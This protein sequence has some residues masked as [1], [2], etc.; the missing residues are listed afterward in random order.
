V[1]SQQKGR[2]GCHSAW[3]YKGYGLRRRISRL[4]KEG[5]PRRKTMKLCSRILTA[6]LACLFL[7]AS[8]FVSCQRGVE[9][10][11]EG[12]RLKAITTLF[13][14]YDFAKNIGGDKVRVTLLL[15]PGV[16]PHSFEPKP[17][18]M[19]KVMAAD[20]FIYTGGSMEPWAEGI[21]K[22]AENKN[23]L[24]VDASRGIDLTQQ[25]AGVEEDDHGHDHG[26]TDPHI[27][28]DMSKAEKMVDNILEGLIKKD[29]TNREYYTRNADSYKTRLREL[30]A[31]YRS[32]LST[33]KKRTFIHGGHFAFGYLAKR[34]NLHYISAYHG[35][36]DAE[37]TPKR[38]IELKNILKRFN[39]HYVFYEELI[40]PR[41]SEI[42][43]QETG[44]ALL[45]LHG[46]HNVSREEMDKGITFLSIMEEDLKNLRVG[47]ECQ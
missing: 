8:F 14:L 1:I 3:A 38:V 30:D 34:Y 16:E 27:W 28:L 24:V 23:L 46:A 15:P 37:P 18:D 41:V 32:A 33:C 9:S 17:G 42:I 7:M 5:I 19:V 10:P 25:R 45:K 4:A 20:L 21:L 35:S 22:G 12:G 36:P 11:A 43:S 6:S 39:L 29:S 26:K 2:R 44:A 13:P 31:R 47:L 40:T